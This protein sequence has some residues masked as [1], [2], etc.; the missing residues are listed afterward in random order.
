MG[1]DHQYLTRF[2]AILTTN[3]LQR[4]YGH[5]VTRVPAL[6]TE[7]SNQARCIPQSLSNR[8]CMYRCQRNF[9]AQR[10]HMFKATNPQAKGMQTPTA[11]TTAGGENR[12]D[13]QKRYRIQG[14][15][16]FIGL[17]IF[18]SS[19]L[20]IYFYPGPYPIDLLATVNVQVVH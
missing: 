5:I 16:W 8:V 11:A 2:L 3:V 4:I 10:L 12:Q 15:L 7:G 20:I 6:A 9:L 13:A 18:I 1:L 19:C 14:I 17:M